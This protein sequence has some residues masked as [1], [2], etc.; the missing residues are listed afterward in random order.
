MWIDVQTFS[1][2]MIQKM[3]Q[4]IDSLPRKRKQEFDVSRE[5]PSS[6]MSR[7]ITFEFLLIPYEGHSLE[8][9]NSCFIA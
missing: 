3:Y 8:T 1:V 7:K 6:G 9:S 2:R 5:G 4:R